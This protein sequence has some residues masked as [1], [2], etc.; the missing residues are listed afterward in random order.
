MRKSPSSGCNSTDV[1]HDLKGWQG[2]ADD[3]T[4][5]W[6]TKP[7]N[8]TLAVCTGRSWT[9][10]RA[11]ID[12]KSCL[13]FT[14]LRLCAAHGWPYSSS[15]RHY[16]LVSF[17]GCVFAWGSR[18]Q[19]LLRSTDQEKNTRYLSFSTAQNSRGA[20]LELWNFVHN[21]IKDNT[22]LIIW[23]SWCIKRKRWVI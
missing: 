4:V 6:H 3:V 8:Q 21:S 18:A 14:G 15:S 12:A 5:V 19:R 2:L 17:W 1:S 7:G 10:A 9:N 23:D 11:G 13:H 20:T 22:F 16:S